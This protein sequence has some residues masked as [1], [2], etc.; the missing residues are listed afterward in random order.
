MAI[1]VFKK[2]G[3]DN[4]FFVVSTHMGKIFLFH[5]EM[6]NCELDIRD[7]KQLINDLNTSIKLIEQIYEDVDAYYQGFNRDYP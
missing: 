2:D 5:P 4:R 7:A 6:G 3:T 1:R